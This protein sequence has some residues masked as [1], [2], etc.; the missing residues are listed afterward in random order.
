MRYVFTKAKGALAN[1]AALM[2]RFERRPLQG[3]FSIEVVDAGGKHHTATNEAEA[4]V[5]FAT[6]RNQG[7]GLP[8]AHT[9]LNAAPGE[10]E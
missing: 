8:K 9:D 6:L 1:E 4:A 7:D 3:R 2:S 10:A 5:L